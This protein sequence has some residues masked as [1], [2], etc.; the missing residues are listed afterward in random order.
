MT[1]NHVINDQQAHKPMT[2]SSTQN[3]RINL[4][5]EGSK[6][7]RT[8][9]V[10]GVKMSQYGDVALL[11]TDEDI[12]KYM[13]IRK[14]A[15]ENQLRISKLIHLFTYIIMAYRLENSKMTQWV[16]CTIQKANIHS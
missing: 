4:L 2:P 14:I 13:K 12:S 1:A 11:Y 6:I 9:K 3:L 8:L 16:L 15:N 5:Q 7:V 10:T